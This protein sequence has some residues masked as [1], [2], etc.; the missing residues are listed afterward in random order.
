MMPSKFRVTSAGAA[1]L[2]GLVAA[3]LILFGTDPLGMATTDI[4]VPAAQAAAADRTA[5]EAGSQPDEHAVK[6][7]HRRHWPRPHLSKHRPRPHHRHRPRPTPTTQ[8]PWPT[9]SPRPTYSPSTAQPTATRQPTVKP[10]A[11]SSTT[12]ASRPSPTPTATRTSATPTATASPTPAAGQYTVRIDWAAAVLSSLNS[13]RAAHGLPALSSNAKLVTSAHRHNVAMAD[14][15]Q[16]SHQ[17][18]GEPS[19]GS[20]ISAAGYSWSSVGENIAYNSNRSQAGVLALQQA[21][22]NETA[23]NDGHRRN[24]LSSSFTEVGV[25]VIDDAKHGKV[26]LVTDFGRP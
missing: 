3:G 11:T 2:V 19:L 25:D 7:L 13:Q 16:L 26:W 6:K 4:A 14:A 5:V 1:G 17:L 10:T 21:M 8:H 24:I 20:R 12:T 22:Y 15:N 23:P 9:Q 18:S